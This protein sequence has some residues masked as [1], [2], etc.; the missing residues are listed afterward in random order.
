[1]GLE[2]DPLNLLSKIEELFEGKNS[3]FCLESREYGVGIRHAHYAIP[4]YPQKLALK[5]P[6]SGGHLIGRFRS[7]TQAMKFACFVYEE[8]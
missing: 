1:M 6:K 2:R 8:Y 4:L 7:R 5:S 3:G